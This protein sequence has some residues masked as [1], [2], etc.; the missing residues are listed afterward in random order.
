M[1]ILS[2]SPNFNQNRNV[3][4]GIFAKGDDNARTVVRE[5]LTTNDWVMQPAYDSWFKRI[6]DD[7]NFIVYTDEK[8][9]KVKGEF[10]EEFV[11]NEDI[12]FYVKT[13][14]RR[15]TLDDLSV[16]SNLK[17]IAERLYDFQK[18]LKGVDLSERWRSKN[19]HGDAR[20]EEKAREDF[21]NN[22]AD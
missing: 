8:T 1:R 14:K 22:L 2:I 15:G 6:E 11:K 21:L 13:L 17:V 12:A 4:F 3:S 9:G 20:E 19:P 5:A 7:E 10:D 16:L 18:I